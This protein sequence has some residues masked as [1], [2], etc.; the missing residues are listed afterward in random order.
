MRR[1]RTARRPHG[2]PLP[3]VV[4]RL[5]EGTAAGGREARWPGRRPGGPRAARRRQEPRRPRRGPGG[6]GARAD[7]KRRA[8]VGLPPGARRSRE[9]DDAAEAR[10]VALPQGERR[11]RILIAEDD[12]VSRRMLEASLRKWGHEVISANDGTGAWEALQNPDAPRLAVLDWMMP[13]ID[14][15]EICRRV[16]RRPDHGAIHIILLTAKGRKQDVVEGLE[17]GADDY[18]TKPFDPGELRARVS[19]GARLLDLQD[20]LAERVG[21]LEAALA[22]VKQLRG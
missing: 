9:R 12:A 22:S 13:G 17:A 11:M 4:S 3:Q 2:R 15:V 6:A 1:R 14:G 10:P 8:P 16:R 5:D 20:A 19:V 21:D 18:V 7:G